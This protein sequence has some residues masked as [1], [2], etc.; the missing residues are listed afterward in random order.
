[1]TLVIIYILF[2]PFV[3]ARSTTTYCYY[4]ILLVV[5]ITHIISFAFWAV[6]F[7]APRHSPCK[8]FSP[9]FLLV[10][11]RAGGNPAFEENRIFEFEHDT[12]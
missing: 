8:I 5:Q 11:T 4:L 3:F 2:V 6:P 12:K 10:E 7:I 1:M 9:C